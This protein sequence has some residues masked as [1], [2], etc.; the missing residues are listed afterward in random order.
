MM[1]TKW[2]TSPLVQEKV[3]IIFK[4]FMSYNTWTCSN[5]KIIT[6]YGQSQCAL[7]HSILSSVKLFFDM[8]VQGLYG[9]IICYKIFV[10]VAAPDSTLHIT[11]TKLPFLPY[12]VL[13]W[14]HHHLESVH[15]SMIEIDV[16]ESFLIKNGVE[17]SD[18]GVWLIEL[19]VKSKNWWNNCL[20]TYS[21]H[22]VGIELPYH[23][24]CHKLQIINLGSAPFLAT[25]LNCKVCSSAKVKLL[26]YFRNSPVAV[27]NSILAQ[28]LAPFSNRYCS[29][30][31][32]SS[33]MGQMTL[34]S[35]SKEFAS[36]EGLNI[37]WH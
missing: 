17:S 2:W 33:Q 14:L 15:W 28:R 37:L 30:S 34:P 21:W 9:W 35:T 8:N 4:L 22:I 25:L 26:K 6:Y 11:T 13:V 36:L 32:M 19:D 7:H 3:H 16:S 18:T 31:R 1:E 5:Q 12:C 23:V 10:W 27:R 29:A 20:M 24:I